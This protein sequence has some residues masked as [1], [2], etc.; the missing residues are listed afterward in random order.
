MPELD[1]RELGR[2]ATEGRI[3]GY[4]DAFLQRAAAYRP[5]E[6]SLKY[7]LLCTPRVGSNWLAHEL[8][9]EGDLGHP[10]EWFSPAY[11]K[12]VLNRLREPFER[13]RYSELVVAGSTSANGVFGLKVQMDQ[14][15]RLKAEQ[16]FDILD[17]GFDKV[18]WIGRRDVIAQAYSYVRSLKMNVFSRFTEQ[19]RKVEDFANPYMIIETSAVLSAAAQLT[20]WREI[21]EQR[22]R[23]YADLCL[24][25]EDMVEHGIDAAVSRVRQLLGQ[26]PSRRSPATRDYEKQARSEEMRRI[27]E[28]KRYLAGSGSLPATSSMD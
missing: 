2:R 23:A 6:I 16:G 15:L 20:R 19:E 12:P 25:Y 21:F 22:Y 17:L 3:E 8:R 27:A 7:L 4:V 26:T 24:T 28:I 11:V 10:Y 9:S 18:I 1:L 5:G 13:R 14:A